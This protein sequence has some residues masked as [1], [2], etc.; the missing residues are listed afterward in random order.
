MEGGARLRCPLPWDTWGHN[1]GAHLANTSDPDW[2][3]I[4]LMPRGG[5]ASP[6]PQTQL[7]VSVPKCM[8][9][10]FSV[11]VPLDSADSSAELLLVFQILACSKDLPDPHPYSGSFWSP[12]HLHSAE[13][14]AAPA[15]FM[16]PCRGRHQAPGLAWEPQEGRVVSSSLWPGRCST[17]I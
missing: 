4:V 10:V 8:H 6:R 12:L 11:A 5:G 2:P 9:G 3:M 16:L 17:N 1:Q 14:P 13:F 15:L 7:P